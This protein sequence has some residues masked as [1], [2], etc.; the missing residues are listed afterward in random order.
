MW[1][2]DH[3]VHN[4]QHQLEMNTEPLPL[5]PKVKPHE[6]GLHLHMHEVYCGMDDTFIVH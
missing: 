2:A 5:L 3:I 4:V 6:R 1:E